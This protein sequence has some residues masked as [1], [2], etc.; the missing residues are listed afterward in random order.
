MSE[1]ERNMV[2]L[3]VPVAELAAHCDPL[4]GEEWD[5]DPIDPADVHGA[6]IAKRFA[7][8]P[9]QEINKRYKGR[10]FDDATYHVE[11]LAYFLANPNDAPLELE[12]EVD[13]LTRR[14]RV[15]LFDGNHRFGAVLLGKGEE[16]RALV[17]EE[18]LEDALRL[19][20]GARVVAEL[21][22]P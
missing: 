8:E 2:E 10:P 22:S 14:N 12:L 4:S 11:R 18:E 20:P 16:V 15:R 9:W 17:D 19:L 1:D 6:L 5:C 7:V 3:L 13:R 21:P